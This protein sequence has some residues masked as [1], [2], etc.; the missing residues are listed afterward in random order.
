MLTDRIFLG[1][2][3]ASPIGQ[4]LLAPTDKLE[5]LAVNDAFLRSVARRREDVLGRPL[6]DVFPNDPDDPH[7][8]GVQDLAR[9][10]RTAIASGASQTMP[11]QRYPIEMHRDGRSWFED[12][13][14]S[15]T[16]SP[17][18]GPDGTLLCVSHTTID[19]TA[20]VRAEQAL[21]LSE[22]QAKYIGVPVDG[23]YKPNHYRY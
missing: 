9:S 7:D 11:A 12:M 10:I 6:F 23:P 13:Y 5:I 22:E 8:T 19:I 15:A 3:H 20:Q 2:F 14:W 1:A 21:K 18:Y 17:V 16:N 4:Y